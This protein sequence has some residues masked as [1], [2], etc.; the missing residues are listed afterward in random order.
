ME[1][2]GQVFCISQVNGYP[3]IRYPRFQ[4]CQL[5]SVA[6]GM[7]FS[8]V[9]EWSIV[10]IVNV[11]CIYSK[12]VSNILQMCQQESCFRNGPAT[13]GPGDFFLHFTGQECIIISKS[14]RNLARVSASEQ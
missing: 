2:Q 14:K 8:S 13:I 12:M 4:P 10:K 6:A 3:S 1:L 7:H 5:F 11:L 9:N